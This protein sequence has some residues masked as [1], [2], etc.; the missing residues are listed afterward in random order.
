MY[1]RAFRAFKQRQEILKGLL[2]DH[3]AIL[4][5]EN[6]QYDN[7]TVGAILKELVEANNKIITEEEKKR[8]KRKVEEK[9]DV[10]S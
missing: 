7:K 10:I 8:K 4:V 6:H 1:K 3:D 2:S 5:P 9:I